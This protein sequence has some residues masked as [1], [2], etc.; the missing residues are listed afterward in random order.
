MTLVGAEVGQTKSPHQ[1]AEECKS[2]EFVVFL[3]KWF[4]LAAVTGCSNPYKIR[5]FGLRIRQT[6]LHDF[7]GR[8]VKYN[9]RKGNTSQPLVGLLTSW[10]HGADPPRHN[11]ND[12]V[13]WAIAIKINWMKKMNA[14]ICSLYH[15]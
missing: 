12:E 4:I 2:T 6:S 7:V 10:H 3:R 1:K 14:D 8:A 15:H 13:L 5:P 9:T 11:M